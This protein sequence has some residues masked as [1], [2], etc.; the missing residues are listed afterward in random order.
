MPIAPAGDIRRQ[1]VVCPTRT[2]RLAMF[3]VRTMDSPMVK[4]KPT[5]KNQHTAV[6]RAATHSKEPIS[7]DLTQYVTTRQAA[8]MLGTDDSN[9]RHLMIAGELLGHKLGHYWLVYV[10]SLK[11]YFRTKSPKGRPPSRVPKIQEKA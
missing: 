7:M 6:S 9:I 8:E 1:S 4:Q 11:K 2:S 3:F 5:L 10:P